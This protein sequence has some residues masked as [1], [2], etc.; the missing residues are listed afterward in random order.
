MR[1][2]IP[3]L[4]AIVTLVSQF[5]AQAQDRI[6]SFAVRGTYTTT[7][8]IF[9]NPDSPSS[10]LRGQYVAL[11]NIYGFGCELRVNLP[12]NTVA[13]ALSAEYLSKL[14]EHTQLVGFT[15]PPRTLPVKEGF[16]FIPIEV[17]A[18]ISIPLGTEQLRFTMG[19][20]VGAYIGKRILTIAGVE[21][22]QQN[23]PVYYGIHVETTFDYRMLSRLSVRAE[24]RFRDPEITAQSRFDQP[25]TQYGG[26]LILLPREPF[27]ARINVNG[28]TFGLGVVFDVF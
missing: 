5:S 7:S 13:I 22:A 24:M 6:V 2:S 19:G 16:R 18:H 14:D 23:N 28:L 25:A 11:D 21:A 27:R 3:S 9:D 4:V 1:R 12:G 15:N 26:V 20:G 17:G 8:K 10:D